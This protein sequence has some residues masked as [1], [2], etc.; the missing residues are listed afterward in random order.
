M[1]FGYIDATAIAAWAA[2]VFWQPSL[3]SDPRDM[4]KRRPSF[5]PPAWIFPLV[6]TI[7]YAMLT[8][9]IFFFTKYTPTDSWQ[10]ITGTVVFVIHIFVNKWWGVVFWDWKRPGVALFLLVGIMLPTIVFFLVLCCLNTEFFYV[11]VIMCGIYIVWLLFATVLNVY[12][13]RRT[14]K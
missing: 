6:W 3:R 12:Y 2:L 5:A 9:A 8:V 7:L 13:V 4:Y 10:L 14:M 1:T 11:P